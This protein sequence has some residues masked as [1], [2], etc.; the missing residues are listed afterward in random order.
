MAGGLGGVP[1]VSQSSQG[2]V[3]GTSTSL[4]RLRQRVHKSGPGST[5]LHYAVHPLWFDKLTMSGNRASS[6]TGDAIANTPEPKTPY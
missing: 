3:G 1:P 2:W 4:C 5:P 6:F